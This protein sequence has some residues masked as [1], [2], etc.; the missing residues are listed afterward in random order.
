MAFRMFVFNLGEPTGRGNYVGNEMSR[1]PSTKLLSISLPHLE[2][3]TGRRYGPWKPTEQVW[4]SIWLSVASVSCWN[5]LRRAGYV[6]VRFRSA[7]FT[8]SD[9]GKV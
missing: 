3:P 6:V 1:R 8:I 5:K 7:N 9:L 4:N 2:A